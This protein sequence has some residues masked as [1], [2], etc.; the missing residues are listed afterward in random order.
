MVCI[1]ERVIVNHGEFTVPVFVNDGLLCWANGCKLCYAMPVIYGELYWANGCE[2]WFAM[3]CQWFWVMV[4]YAVPGV[5]IM[6]CYT[7]PVVVN[8]AVL[9]Y[10]EWLGIMVCNAESVVV[11]H[12]VLSWASGC[13][14]CVLC[15][16]EQLWTMLCY[17]EPIVFEL[18]GRAIGYEWY[19]PVV[20]N[21]GVL[22]WTS[23]CESWCVM[24]SQWLWIIVCY[25]DPLVMY[26]GVLWWASGCESWCVILNQGFWIIVCYAESL[27]V[28]HGML[29]W[30]SRCESWC[31]LL[32]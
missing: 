9:Y 20:V 32:N 21:Y 22:C 18:W 28:N 6:M 27:V 29:C 25:T 2:S 4:S 16:P 5:L 12:G 30:V 17:T 23:G 1:A 26:R 24:L 31:V 11:N 8:H 15:W 19:E 13:E 3:L 10:S 7:E 14:S